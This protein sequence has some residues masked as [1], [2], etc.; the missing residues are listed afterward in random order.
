MGQVHWQAFISAQILKNPVASTIEQNCVFSP[1]IVSQGWLR[2]HQSLWRSLLLWNP[3]KRW[4]RDKVIFVTFEVNPHRPCESPSGASTQDKLTFNETGQT[5]VQEQVA[6]EETGILGISNWCY[7]RMCWS[8][9]PSRDTC[10]PTQQ[11][12]WVS[13]LDIGRRSFTEHKLNLPTVGG[14][15]GSQPRGLRP[16]LSLGG[17]RLVHLLRDEG[18][19]DSDHQHW[20]RRSDVCAQSRM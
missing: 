5:Y 14:I 8:V 11:L 6:F 1:S 17:S 12:H 2:L 10:P 13:V 7:Q 18:S 4:I 3:W 20:E 9:V 15:S 19:E 16:S